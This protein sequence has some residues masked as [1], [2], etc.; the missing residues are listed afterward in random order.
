MSVQ[1]I[2]FEP[3]ELVTFLIAFFTFAAGAFKLLLS[4]FN[5]SLDDKFETFKAEREKDREDWAH[6]FEQISKLEREFLVH[7]ADLP[8]SFV[9]RD[10]Y[11]RGQTVIE[12]KL[13][14]LFTMIQY[15]RKND[16]THR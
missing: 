8:K 9:M 1:V 13:D 6:A 5:K 11:V 14:R 15:G 4:L 7:K 2:Q 3:W 10:D 16:D 12:A